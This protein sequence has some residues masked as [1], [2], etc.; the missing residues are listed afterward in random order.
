ML[1]CK[2]VAQGGHKVIMILGIWYKGAIHE[3]QLQLFTRAMPI[4]LLILPII[5]LRI[6]FIQLFPTSTYY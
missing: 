6:S 1:A 3:F 4:M 2:V 5:L